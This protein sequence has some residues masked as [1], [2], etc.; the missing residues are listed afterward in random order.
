MAKRIL[1]MVAFAVITTWVTSGVAQDSPKVADISSC[2]FANGVRIAPC[3]IAYRSLGTLNAAGDNAVLI[4]TWLLG[5]SEDWTPFL[6]PEGIVDPSVYYVVV[7]DALS[8]GQSQSPSNT[9]GD[10]RRGFEAM[11]IG[12]MVESQH[13]LLTEQLGIQKLHA[14][15][16]YSMGAIQA[17]EWSVRYPTFMDRVVAMAGSPRLGAYDHLL[18]S[19]MQTM[20]DDG[21]KGRLPVDAIWQQLSRLDAL[22]SRT[23]RAVNQAT[24]A[25]L[26]QEVAK[27][28]A[29][30][31][32]T[33][34]LEDYRAQIA[35]I[36]RQDVAADY[37]GDLAKA[38]SRIRA[39]MMLIY[40]WDD[41]MVTAENVGAFGRLAGAEILEVATPCGHLMGLCEGARI[42][43][44]VRA[45]LAR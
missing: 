34:A 44:A 32:D 24:P 14:V 33:W 2:H 35:A 10:G 39:K 38:A 18:W 40:S 29:T 15:V 41:H 31:R 5:R 30:Y 37:D 27:S 8:D 9:T 17:I 45:F 42:S 22:N 20:I 16:G 6:G 11:T 19:T 13:R 23:P 4:P 25:A 26:D 43:S 7:V 3:R 28:T 21:V 36:V 1:E 12:D